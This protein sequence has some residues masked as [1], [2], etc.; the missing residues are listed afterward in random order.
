MHF[1]EGILYYYRFYCQKNIEIETYGREQYRITIILSITV[2]GNKLPPFV[3][4]NGESDK[5][6]ENHLKNF[7]Y[8]IKINIY[9]KKKK[10]M[11]YN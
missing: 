4:L 6:I 1:G 7:E 5:T 8:D 11:V 10:R 9:L 3:I 2:D